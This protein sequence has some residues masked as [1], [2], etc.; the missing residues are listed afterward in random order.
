M[1]AY[2]SVAVGFIMGKAGR[3]RAFSLER[4]YGD[5][6]VDNKKA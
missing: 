5:M 4:V 2:S 6:F 3:L 1:L